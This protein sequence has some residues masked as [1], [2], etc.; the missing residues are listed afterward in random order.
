MKKVLRVL[1]PVLLTLTI[2]VCSAWYLFIYDR[3]FTRDILLSCARWS[4]NN[5][6][7]NIATW[8]YNRAYAHDGNSDA[9]A[10]ELA[11]QYIDNNNYTKAEYTLTNAIS[12]G[13]GVDVY[14]KLCKTFVEQDKLLDAVAML[15]GIDNPQ[16]KQKLDSMRPSA[17]VF[18]PDPSGDSGN[19]FDDYILVTLSCDAGT[20]Y[21]TDDGTYPTIKST[22]NEGF[23]MK[24]GTNKVRAVVVGNNGLVSSLAEREYQ[25]HGVVEEIQFAD[26]AV[27]AEVHSLL[28]IAADKPILSPHM[29]SITEFTIPSGAEKFDDIRHMQ[30]LEKLTIIDGMSGQLTSIDFEKLTCLHTLHIANTDVSYEELDNIVKTPEL[31]DL[32]LSGAGIAGITHLSSATKL[33]KLDISGNSIRTLEPLTNLV[34]LQ[35]LYLRDNA[36]LDLSPLSQLAALTVLDVTNNQITTLAPVTSLRNLVH[37]KASS[38]NISQMGNIGKMTMLE[39]LYL[40]DNQLTSLTT[41]DTCTALKDI[42]IEKNQLS[43]I[44]VL[45]SMV[46][47]R[48]LD[49]S[50]NVV[51]ELPE[52][53]K[54]CE[55]VTID[56]SF[57]LLSDLSQL[58]GLKN[59]NTVNMESNLE[60]SSLE[61]LANC[62]NLF[63]VNVINTKVTEVRVLTDKSISVLYRVPEIVLEQEQN[64]AETENNA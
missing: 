34:D 19:E 24:D 39:I 33:V 8:F 32:T 20:V 53:S 51:S 11:Q 30:Y 21:A 28:G 37:L 31:R 55:L 43:D 6:R 57:N 50:D 41:L 15:D 48:Y 7:H 5:G 27:E 23:R 4:E 35:E 52:F 54:D 12:D 45:S 49:F 17:P 60:I 46:G 29:W 58:S 22:V 13:G 3:E 59:L 64:E 9:V 25:I 61:P 56:G 2:I 14:V 36:I 38:N 44:S 63:R 16:I 40:D 18:T 47:L 62:R 1:I 10:I 42:N 26:P